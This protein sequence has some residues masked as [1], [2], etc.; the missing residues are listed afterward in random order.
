MPTTTRLPG[1]ESAPAGTPGR[2]WLEA[3]I[4]I[5]RRAG[6][7]ILEVYGT[8]FETRTKADDSPLTQADLRAHRL[9]LAGLEELEPRLPVLSEESSEIPWSERSSW[10][11]YW[12]VDPLDGTKEFVSRNGEFTV[13]IALI[14]G[15]RPALGVVHIPVSDTTYSG[16]P[17]DGAWREAN[18][19]GRA[20]ISV[21]RVARSPLRVVGSRS[22]GN[23][24]LQQALDAL[25]PHEL[26]PAGSSIKLCLVAD[27][28]VD[29]Y[30]RLG[31]T[32]EWDI[33]AGQAVVEAAGGQVVRL[34]DGQA[35]RYNAQ[36][37]YLN[38][39]FLAYGDPDCFRRWRR[40]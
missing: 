34:G 3:V 27:G 12:L 20:A 9:I 18:D 37:G 28:S 32:S 40:G 33:A 38:P 39:D 14:D 22:H 4:D 10:Q 29:L 8:D 31:P 36:D 5:A 19:R 11:R 6:R 21:R 26:R 17:G 15:H 30:P 13:N 1:S 23:P 35:L 24:G 7:E 2:A 25:G 16:I